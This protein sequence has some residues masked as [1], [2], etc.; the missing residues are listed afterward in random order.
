VHVLFY[1]DD[2][3][4]NVPVSAIPKKKPSDFF[5]TLSL[6]EGE[7]LQEYINQSRNELERDI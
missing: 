7:K 4:K 1:T 5:G 6:E 2:E 3:A